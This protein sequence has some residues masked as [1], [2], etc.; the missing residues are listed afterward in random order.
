MYITTQVANWLLTKRFWSNQAGDQLAV[1]GMTLATGLA[2]AATVAI[3]IHNI[4]DTQGV[5]DKNINIKYK[6]T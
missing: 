3:I 2:M 5:R 1:V 6:C 4:R